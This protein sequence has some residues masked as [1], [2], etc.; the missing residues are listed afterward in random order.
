MYLF[1]FFMA[2][3]CNFLSFEQFSSNQVDAIV[4][5]D[6]SRILGLGDLGVGGVGISVGK[7]IERLG[8]FF[9]E[10]CQQKKKI[11]LNLFFNKN[12]GAARLVC[13]RGRF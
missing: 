10:I 9:F 13:C 3:S 12:A 5:T 1:F 6:G 4:V 7:V 8:G 2:L 11:P